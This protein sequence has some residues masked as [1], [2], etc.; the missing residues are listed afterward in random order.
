MKSYRDL[1]IKVKIP[2]MLGIASL[3]VFALVCL[4]LL[5]PL[6]KTSLNYSASLAQTSATA[7]SETLAGKINGIAS[8]IRAYS[9][10]VE[11]VI[12]SDLFEPNKKREFILEDLDVILKRESSLT[13]IWCIFEPNAVDGLDSLFKGRRGSAADGRFIPYV[14]AGRISTASLD[15]IGSALYEIPK[16][17]GREIISEPYTVIENGI[18]T[19]IFSIS[20][21]IMSDG[22]FIGVIGS[23]YSIHELNELIS[24]INSYGDGKL[25]TD[26]GIIAVYRDINRVGNIAERGNREILDRLP[27]GKMFEGFYELDGEVQYKVYIPVQLGIDCKP[28]YFAIDVPR[29]EIYASS[30]KTAFNLISYCILGIILITLAAWLLITPTLKGVTKITHLL[31]KISIGNINIEV[32]NNHDKDE[33]GT[34][35]EK[36]GDVISDLKNMANFAHNIG[37][38]NLNAEYTALSESD[39]LGNSLLDMRLSLQ[40]AEKEQAIRAKEEEQRNWGTAGLAKFAEILR[41][42]NNNME[43]LAY[44]VV[45]NLVKYLDINQGGL[46]VMN[47]SEHEEDRLLDMKAS[48]AFDRKKFIEKHIRPGEGLVGT[49]YLEGETIYITQVPDEY[50]A[51]T[52][53]LGDANP[54]ALLISPLKVNDQI[55]GVL[56]LASFKPF[57]PY[58]L[59]FIQKVSESIAA[60]ISTVN[61]NIRTSRLLEQS[62]L[63]AEELV[64][65][66]EEIRQTMEEMQATQEEMRRREAELSGTLAQMQEMQEIT[67]EN[68]FEMQ[69]FHDGIFATNNVVEFSNKGIITNVNQNLCELFGLDRSAFV[70]KHLSLF[71]GEEEF[72]KALQKLE[73]DEIYENL[74]QVNVSGKTMSIKQKFMPICCKDG[75]LKNAMLLAFHDQAEDMRQQMAKLQEEEKMFEEKAH[76]YESLLDAFYSTPI[77]VTDMDKKITFLNKAALTIL[78]TK[79]E[80]VLGKYCG[81]VWGVDICKDERCG[82]EHLKCGKGKSVFQVDD[83]VFTTLASYIKDINGNKIGHVEVVE[84]ITEVT[85]DIEEKHHQLLTL[86]NLIFSSLNVAEF[87]DEGN[88]TDMNQNLLDLWGVDKDFFIGKHYSFFVGEEA[89]KT[90]WDD[91][92][93][94]KPHS[95]TRPVTTSKGTKV[96]KHNFMPICDKEGKLLEVVLLAFPVDEKKEVEY[97]QKE[98]DDFNTITSNKEK[99]KRAVKKMK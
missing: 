29:N 84:N 20:I 59:D 90:V 22:K 41:R 10:L 24:R 60:T 97:T 57:E 2:L 7:C 83:Q 80:D 69:Q 33:V 9:G 19:V 95:D 6:R 89:Y 77:S 27:E 8:I 35:N 12:A 4:L 50:I 88:V 68:K 66:E 14:T 49:C 94:G 63:Q 65:H 62:K 48:F 44:N 39:M 32:E 52:S 45:S 43:A 17:T 47:E 28:W 64:N 16:I 11:N 79:R 76:W 82:I 86:R 56:E 26:K 96:F 81:D 54:R 30:Q 31:E 74:Q 46:F 78:Q 72:N 36:L 5:I 37:K 51:I 34:M 61:V 3:F 23:R 58:Q 71:I 93:Q 38:G 18:E 85:R 70:D 92:V 67:E 53:G 21:P 25:V 13:N 15:V 1:S 87:S 98:Q 75:N 73:R 91:M 42:D 55:F 40:N 99:M